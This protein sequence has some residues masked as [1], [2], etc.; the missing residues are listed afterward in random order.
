M[1]KYIIFYVTS[2]SYDSVVVD[3]ES[4]DDAFE[5]A[6]VFSRVHAVAIMGIFDQT[7][8]FKIHPHE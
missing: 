7:C 8:Y 1:K 6:R 4:L 3:A 2:K 5:T